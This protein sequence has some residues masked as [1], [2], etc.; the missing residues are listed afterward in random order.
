MAQRVYWNFK[1][2]DSTLDLIHKDSPIRPHG[3]YR[4]FDLFSHSALNITLGHSANYWPKYDVEFT[5]TQTGVWVTKQGAVVTETE[6]IT[7]PIEANN[8]ANSRTDLIV[9]N[10]HYVSLTGGVVATYSV[11][12]GTEYTSGQDLPPG[13]GTGDGSSDNGANPVGTYDVILGTLI[14]P[15]NSASD[16]SGAVFYPAPTPDF[17]ND[18][19]IAH[20]DRE[21]SYTGLQRFKTFHIEDLST[22]A[23]FR[24]YTGVLTLPTYT[25][26]FG[27]KVLHSSYVVT[28]NSA[29]NAFGYGDISSLSHDMDSVPTGFTIRLYFSDQ[30]KLNASGSFKIDFQAYN[31]WVTIRKS[32][33]ATESWFIESD[34]LLTTENAIFEKNVVFQEVP[35]TLNA[36]AIDFTTSGNEGNIL[37]LEIDGG[38]FS[39]DFMATKNHRLVAS[40][41][42]TDYKGGIYLLNIIRLNGATLTIKHDSSGSGSL[43]KPFHLAGLRDLK[44]SQ[45]TSLILVEGS[46][47]WFV[48][49]AGDTLTRRVKDSL[50]FSF[51][52]PYSNN[53]NSFYPR[54]TGN[55]VMIAGTITATFLSGHAAD[56]T[57]ENVVQLN[58]RYY[59]EEEFKGILVTARE[60]GN[61]FVLNITT[62]GIVQISTRNGDSITVPS[63]LTIDIP[64]TVF[65]SFVLV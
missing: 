15:A 51:Y 35:V 1:D 3:R 10:H 34:R 58:S 56:F 52:S 2:D 32:N 16:L 54:R 40:Q 13:L 53:N 50:G 37:K 8:T 44:I 38:S 33:D 9:G 17:S 18:N 62:N 59:P 60:T 24:R 26:A 14:V 5:E 42:K 46:D 6:T 63:T 47:C 25:D 61:I 21:Q 48:I 29:T 11:I 19:S 65:E 57:N 12:K 43:Q 23:E 28:E 45:S 7:V 55:K 41:D 22:S 20:K 30:A 64:P 36:G 27:N 49:G 39:V 31:E 4:G